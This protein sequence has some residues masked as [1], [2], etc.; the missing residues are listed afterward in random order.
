M[1]LRIMVPSVHSRRPGP[2]RTAWHVISQWRAEALRREALAA[3][4]ARN[5]EDAG[6]SPA[7]I[8]LDRNGPPSSEGDG[9]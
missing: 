6:L 4:P 9:R 2:L 8:W 1:R 5:L 3:M 7:S